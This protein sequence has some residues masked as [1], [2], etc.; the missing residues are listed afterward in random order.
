MRRKSRI[1]TKS[2]VLWS[3]SIYLHNIHLDYLRGAAS[4]ALLSSGYR[5]ANLAQKVP[6]GCIDMSFPPLRPCRRKIK[7]E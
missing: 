4:R 6:K 1:F 5:N 3:G 2:M 7:E